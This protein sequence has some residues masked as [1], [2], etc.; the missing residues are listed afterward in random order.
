MKFSRAL[1]LSAALLILL[2]PVL[3]FAQIDSGPDGLGIYFDEG[4]TVVSSTA[5]TGDVVEAYLIATNLTQSGDVGLWAAGMCPW[6]DAE[7]YGTPTHGGFNYGMNMP[8]D[9]C[10]SCI[11]FSF[12]TPMPV[13]NIVILSLFIFIF[14]PTVVIIVLLMEVMKSSPCTHLQ[15]QRIYLWQPLTEMLRWRLRTQNG[16]LSKP[17]TGN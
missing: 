5:V 14:V 4:A 11:T 13:G 3:A 17:C 16:M 8:G 9:S 12:D 1:W 2:L 15:G 6:G 10:W 7:I